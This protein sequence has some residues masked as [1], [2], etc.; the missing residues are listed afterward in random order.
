M[1]GADGWVGSRMEMVRGG[2]RETVRMKAAYLKIN[3][4]RGLRVFFGGHM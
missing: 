4:G 3:N 1:K 2:T